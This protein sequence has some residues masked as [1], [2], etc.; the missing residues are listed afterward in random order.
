MKTVSIYALVDPDDGRTYYIGSTVNPSSRASMHWREARGSHA[1][2]RKNTWVRTVL[3]RN[4]KPLMVILEETSHDVAWQSEADWI[5][6]ARE[7]GEPLLNT[8]TP[9][10]WEA[11]RADARTR[12][13]YAIAYVADD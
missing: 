10:P 12:N 1:G 11:N 9:K 5:A 2:G 13:P 4:Q 3:Q 7:M 8:Q 6:L